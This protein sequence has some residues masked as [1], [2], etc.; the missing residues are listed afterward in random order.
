MTAEYKQCGKSGDEERRPACGLLPG[1]HTPRYEIAHVSVAT[2]I[3]C[4][5]RLIETPM[6]HFA[7]HNMHGYNFLTIDHKKI[8][9][10]ST[11]ALES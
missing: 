8:L 10:F 11:E 9:F 5:R 2:V 4:D 3:D 7:I 1:G 6:K